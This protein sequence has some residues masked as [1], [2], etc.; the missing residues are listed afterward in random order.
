MDHRLKVAGA[1]HKIFGQ[2]AISEIFAFAGGYPRLIN[3]ICDHAL[4]TGYASDLKLIDK[5]VIKECERELQIPVDADFVNGGDQKLNVTPQKKSPA[6]VTTP[7]KPSRMKQTSII[8]AIIMLLVLGVYF[9]FSQKSGDSPRWSMEE[10]APQKYKGSSPPSTEGGEKTEIKTNS[11]KTVSPAEKLPVDDNAA[12]NQVKETAPSAK[13]NRNHATAQ[14]EDAVPFP[15]KEKKAL[16]YFKHN[17]NELPDQSFE[18][19]NHNRRLYASQS[20]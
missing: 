4:L 9:F 19:L 1:T 2:D 5:K 20:R 7:V 3:I 10:I 16:I 17:S 11:I 6:P 13:Y 8:A 12:Q 18:A 14:K 15:F